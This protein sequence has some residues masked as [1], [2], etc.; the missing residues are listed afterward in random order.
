MARAGPCYERKRAQNIHVYN[1]INPV[2]NTANQNTENSLYIPRYYTQPS[3]VALIL[4]H[5]H[6]IFYGMV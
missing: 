1:S 2:N 5:G 6:C 3:N 4:L